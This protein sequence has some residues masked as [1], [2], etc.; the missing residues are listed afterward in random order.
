MVIQSNQTQTPEVNQTFERFSFKLS[1]L[2]INRQLNV[3]LLDYGFQEL[4]MQPIIKT[5]YILF[6]K[7]PEGISF[8]DLK[9]YQAEIC[10]IYRTISPHASKEILELNSSRL[11]NRQDNS[12]NEK[13]SRIKGLIGSILPESIARQYMITGNRSEPKKIALDRS[14]VYWEEK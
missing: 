9:K 6:L 11:T 13:I 12:M 5:V 7:H 3:Y 2:F 8:Y 4:K 10:E 1:R 14:L